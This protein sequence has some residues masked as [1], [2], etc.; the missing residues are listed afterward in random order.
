L[1]TMRPFSGAGKAVR[2]ACAASATAPATDA[3]RAAVSSATA[4]CFTGSPP[5]D[6]DPGHGAPV[7]G[8]TV[9]GEDQDSGRRPVCASSRFV[10]IVATAPRA[11][12]ASTQIVPRRLTAVRRN[13]EAT[14]QTG[15]SD[16]D[17]HD[18][19]HTHQC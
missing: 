6:D 12:Y 5:R 1:K 17:R 18:H 7:S 11:L 10:R 19:S 13:L 15:A 4:S 14:A 16:A 8:L 9:G 2:S 3:I